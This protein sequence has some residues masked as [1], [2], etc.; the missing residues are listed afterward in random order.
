M[1][2]HDRRGPPAYAIGAC[3]TLLVG[4]AAV[5][6]GRPVNAYATGH[7]LF[8]YDYGVIRRGLLGTLVSPLLYPLPPATARAMIGM[9]GQATTAAFFIGTAWLC[10]HRWSDPRRSSDWIAVPAAFYASAEAARLWQRA[11]YFDV[12]LLTIGIVCIV[13]GASR[14]LWTRPVLG[15]LIGVGI[16]VHETFLLLVLPSVLLTLGLRERVSFSGDLRRARA[17][18]LAAIGIALATF[19]LVAAS[20]VDLAQLKSAVFATE[21]VR[22]SDNPRMFYALEHTI[23]SAHERSLEHW[24]N[25]LQPRQALLYL[26]L[27]L[28]VL[29]IVGWA[30]LARLGRS[31]ARGRVCT[32]VVAWTVLTIV[33][34]LALHLVTF[35]PKRIN[36][37][38]PCVAVLVWLGVALTSEAEDLDAEPTTRA[39]G[40]WLAAALVAVVAGL[41]TATPLAAHKQ[42]QKQGWKPPPSYRDLG[43]K[44]P[45]FANSGFE[46]GDLDN[47]QATGDA[48]QAQPTYRDNTVLRGKSAAPD[49]DFWIGTHESN[50][51][52]GAITGEIA[53][54]RP[55]GVLRSQPFLVQGPQ[56][57]FKLGGGKDRQRLYVALMVD[58]AEVFRAT[59]HGGETMRPVVV[60]V[61]AYQGQEMWITV[62]DK[63]SAAGGHINVDGFA[64][65]RYRAP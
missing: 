14:R 12:V 46:R 9:L 59:G 15:V 1:A 38:V 24:R 37:F 32:G 57:V 53:G 25:T 62:A 65:L 2:S 28:P 36:G 17:T 52:P 7:W 30:I 34:P 19:T 23:S 50:P 55:Q 21:V 48:F 54:D 16:L 42:A 27:Y 22:A 3:F 33:S 41:F 39:T 49:G 35:D 40:L 47:W 43:D 5:I 63:S 31:L 18:M 6:G 56:L 58:G 26:V 61:R 51:A 44:E 13:L 4:T 20:E 45:L 11:G 60:D 10:L 29:T 8:T 64:Y